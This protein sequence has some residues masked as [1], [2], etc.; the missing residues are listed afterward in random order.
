MSQDFER[1]VA[2]LE[3]RVADLEKLIASGAQPQDREYIVGFKRTD[4]GV[5]KYF[6][7][8]KDRILVMCE[9]W[10]QPTGSKYKARVKSILVSLGSEELLKG[11]SMDYYKE[12][13]ISLFGKYG[14]NGYALFDN[15][16]IIDTEGDICATR[17]S[18]KKLKF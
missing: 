8:S 3:K 16:L 5:N 14:K 13:V 1:R 4:Y 10:L 2:D 18:S 9:D 12:C 17:P 7:T 15:G 6:K 11:D